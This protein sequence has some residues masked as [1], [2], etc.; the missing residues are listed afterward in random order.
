MFSLRNRDNL[1][2]F[3]APLKNEYDEKAIFRQG[4]YGPT[5]GEGRDLYIATNAGSNVGS[6]ADKFGFNY[7]APPGYTVGQGNTPYLLAGSDYFTPAEIEI[8]YLH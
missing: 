6:K 1:P 4:N 7:R 8:L 5:F 3:K 2:P